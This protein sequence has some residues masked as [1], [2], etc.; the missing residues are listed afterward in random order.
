VTGRWPCRTRGISPTSTR[1]GTALWRQILRAHSRRQFATIPRSCNLKR[2]VKSQLRGVSL[3]RGRRVKKLMRPA[4]ENIKGNE[5][6]ALD[7]KKNHTSTRPC[8]GSSGWSSLIGARYAAFA[9]RTNSRSSPSRPDQLHRATRVIYGDART[10]RG[11]VSGAFRIGRRNRAFLNE[12]VAELLPDQN[13]CK[14]SSCLWERIV[15][16]WMDVHPNRLG[17]Q[18]YRALAHLAQTLGNKRS[19]R[20]RA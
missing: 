4:E 7:L 1:S 8:S 13:R 5:I 19:G 3:I 16:S 17:L 20:F 12:C 10:E 6:G 18:D 14:V 9:H 11:A 15:C 2:Y